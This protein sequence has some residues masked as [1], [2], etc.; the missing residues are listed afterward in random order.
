MSFCVLLIKFR[1]ST[2]NLPPRFKKFVRLPRGDKLGAQAGVFPDS[3]F[4]DKASGT[5]GASFLKISPSARAQALDRLARVQRAVDVHQ[6]HGA[7]HAVVQAQIG[8]RLVEGPAVEQ[9]LSGWGAGPWSRGT[10]G[11]A[12]SSGIT[13]QLRL[14]TSDNY[15]AD[16]VLAPRGGPI[17]YW[18]DEL[19]VS[20]RAQSLSSL[21]NAATAL[22]DA[23]TFGSGATSITVTSANAPYIYPYMY[24][25]GSNIPANTIVDPGYTTGSTTVPIVDATTLAAASTTGASSGT[26]QFSYAGAFAPTATYQVIS[27]AIQEFI[28]AFGAQSYTPG[29]GS[30]TCAPI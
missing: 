16:L 21:A 20:T 27:S 8:Q 18:Q 14:W 26:Y 12:Y 11:S 9:P 29:I 13:Q 24:I 4:S 3:P 10:W 1:C 28:I 17:F 19:G 30:N 23:S 5:T 2:L 7:P 6:Q 25:T 15:G 22:T